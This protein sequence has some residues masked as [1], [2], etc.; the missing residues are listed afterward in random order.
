MKFFFITALCLSAIMSA[1]QVQAATEL[2]LIQGGD[3][4]VGSPTSE[5]RR[6]KMRYAIMSC[7]LPF[8]WAAGK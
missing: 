2:V 7:C 6:E 5:N 8:T 1:S 4:E 3:F